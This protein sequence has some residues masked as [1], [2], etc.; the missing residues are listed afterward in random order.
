MNPID[1]LVELI[2]TYPQ[3]ALLGQA[4]HDWE[5]QR[6]A[7]GVKDRAPRLKALGNAVNPLQFYPIMQAIKIV[8][9]WL[10]RNIQ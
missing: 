8:D 3:P 1:A 9:D 10:R 7:V 4:Q 6:V 5:P 2:A